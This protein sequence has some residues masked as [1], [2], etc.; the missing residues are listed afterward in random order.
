MPADTLQILGDKTWHQPM[1]LH[2]LGNS[3]VAEWSAKL[4]D[5]ISI[6]LAI[7]KL[8]RDQYVVLWALQ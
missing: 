1:F 7:V 5:Q 8:P 3:D 2:S 6:D 4:R